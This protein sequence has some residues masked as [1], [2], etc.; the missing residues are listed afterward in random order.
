M[1]DRTNL[2]YACSATSDKLLDP[3]ANGELSRRAGRL[4]AY[5]SCVKVKS[6]FDNYKITGQVLFSFDWV[7]KGGRFGNFHFER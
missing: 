6:G 3:T 4:C 7:A 1:S 5:I 2:S